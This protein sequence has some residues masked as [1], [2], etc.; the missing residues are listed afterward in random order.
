MSTIKIAA[1][2]DHA[3]FELKQELIEFLKAG[4]FGERSFEIQDLGTHNS[5]SVDYPDFGKA[6]GQAVANGDADLGLCICGSGQGIS[7]AA[8]KIP[9]IRAALVY[10]STTAE[11]ARAHNDANVICFGGRLTKSKVAKESLKVFLE[12]EFEGGRHQARVD[13]LA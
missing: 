7:I 9:G 13:K 1:G 6:V 12:T 3:G 8:N 5:E 2:S 4:D 10:D 11:L